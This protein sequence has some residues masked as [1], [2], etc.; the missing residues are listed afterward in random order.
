M[1]QEG[2]HLL[3]THASCS[4]PA[5]IRGVLLSRVER[6]NIIGSCGDGSDCVFC[7]AEHCVK[8][9]LKALAQ[10]EGAES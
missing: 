10:K 8:V 2:S 4:D 1:S 5:V 6:V 3:K 9:V 7:Q